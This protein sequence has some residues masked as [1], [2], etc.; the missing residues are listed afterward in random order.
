MNVVIGVENHLPK[1]PNLIT[2]LPDVKVGTTSAITVPARLRDLW[3]MRWRETGSLY[4]LVRI[5]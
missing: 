4:H 5:F 1:K 2:I 3:K